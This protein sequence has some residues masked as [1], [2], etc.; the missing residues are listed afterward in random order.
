MKIDKWKLGS[1]DDLNY[2]VLTP[3]GK[4]LT[5]SKESLSKHA[6]AVIAKMERMSKE[7][8]S[9]DEMPAKM[10]EGGDISSSVESA[11]PGSSEEALA[12]AMEPMTMDKAQQMSQNAGM[13]GTTAEVAA[14]PVIEEAIQPAASKFMSMAQKIRQAALQ[15]LEN[16]GPQQKTALNAVDAQA[17][18]A[19]VEHLHPEMVQQLEKLPPE[20]AMDM[21]KAQPQMRVLRQRASQYRNM[22]NSGTMF[23]EGG[24]AEEGYGDFQPPTVTPTTAGASDSYAPEMQGTSDSYAAP[25]TPEQPMQP[26]QPMPVAGPGMTGAFAK[27][28]AANLASAAATAGQGKAENEAIENMQAEQDV[29]PSQ[30]DILDEHSAKEQELFD[31]YA[32]GKIDPNRLYNNTSTGN[33]VLA[34]LGMLLSGMGSGLSGQPNMAASVIEKAIERDIDAQKNDQSTNLNLYKMNR[35]RTNSDLEANLNAQ[36]QL[37]TGVK[38]SLQQAA[39]KYKGPQALAA[40][41]MANAQIDQKLAMNNAML[42]YMNPTVESMGGASP[43]SAQ[44]VANHI[45]HLRQGSMMFPQLAQV[46]KDQESRFI[47]PAPG[48]PGYMTTMPMAQPERDRISNLDMVNQS[49]HDAIAFKQQMDKMGPISPAN[50]G[51]AN[52]MQANL[53][54][55]IGKYVYG[56]SRMPTE[57]Q[58]KQ[59]RNSYGDMNST[60]WLGTNQAALEGL[61]KNIAMEQGTILSSKQARPLK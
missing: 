26:Q 43:D 5:V 35:E 39:S 17:Q 8:T 27:E 29:L 11:A 50:R 7:S 2:H 23:A 55:S 59:I 49:V 6:Q 34:G 14:A 42:S 38:Y 48:R 61:K 32:K 13:P 22:M 3:G 47:P 18:Q 19:M 25:A 52:A 53:E 1:E 46:V 20:Q 60:N 28:K 30:Q 45:N 21:I 10:A 40:A 4:T 36:N 24:E 31:N 41:Q 9:G 37:Y 33:K 57:D 54:N 12:G 58:I 44:G 15:G 16:L 56:F 51:M